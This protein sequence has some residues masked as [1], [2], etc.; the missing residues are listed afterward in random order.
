MAL[1]VGVHTAA[2]SV[3]HTLSYL[4]FKQVVFISLVAVASVFVNQGA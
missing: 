4:M 1:A 2:I 3:G